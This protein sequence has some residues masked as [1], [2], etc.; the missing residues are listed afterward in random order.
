ME[1]R[2]EPAAWE[3][4]VN[5]IAASLTTPAALPPLIAE[6]RAGLLSV[7]DG[8]HRLAA[9]ERAGWPA[10]WVI[11]W[12]NAEAEYR[13]GAAEVGGGYAFEGRI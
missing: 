1:Y 12:Y 3:R 8:N 5:A 9:I 6:Y 4:R 13:A 11:I 7:R 10:T 2:V